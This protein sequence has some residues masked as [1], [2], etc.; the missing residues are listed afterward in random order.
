MMLVINE[1]KTTT[2]PQPLKKRRKYC[3]YNVEVIKLNTRQEAQ[4]ISANCKSHHHDAVL[5]DLSHHHGAV[6]HD[7]T[8]MKSG[9]IHCLHA[10][11]SYE[12]YHP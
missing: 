5:H 7:L 1:Q 6:L 3:F 10:T 8:I 2:Q 4:V 12:H 9:R 11:A